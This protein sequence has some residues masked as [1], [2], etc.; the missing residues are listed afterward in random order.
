MLSALRAWLRS[1]GKAMPPRV[2]GT[3]IHIHEDNWGMR[4]LY[5]LSALKEAQVDIAAAAAAGEQNRDPSG[6]GWSGVHVIQPPAEGYA[7]AGLLLADAARVLEP[8]M[9]RVKHFYA[10]SFAAIDRADRD[11]WGSYDDDAWSFGLSH[12]CYL[13]LDVKDAHVDRIWF[14]LGHDT[15]EHADALRHALQAIDRLVPSLIADYYMDVTVEIGDAEKL[16]RYFAQLA[17]RG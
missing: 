2:D 10:T 6:F 7:E 13:K 16:D 14:D 17:E 4:N 11:P 8:I 1:W 9:P 15:A 3:V 5:P 12:R